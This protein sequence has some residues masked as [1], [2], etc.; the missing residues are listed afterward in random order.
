MKKVYADLSVKPRW[1]F[2]YM[3]TLAAMILAASGSMA[4]GSARVNLNQKNATLPEVF[5]QVRRQTSLS[6]IFSNDDVAGIGRK[7]YVIQDATVDQAMK[8]VLSGTALEYEL[9]NNVI[10][11]RQVPGGSTQASP[12]IIKGR[13]L[14]QGGAPLVGATVA[15]V[16]TTAGAITDGNGSFELRATGLGTPTVRI[17]YVGYIS[18]DV[19]YRGADINVTLESST[20]EMEAVVVTGIFDRRADSYTGANAHYNKTEIERAGNQNL[21]QALRNLDPSFNVLE[22]NEFGSDPNRLPDIEMRGTSNFSDMRDRYQ[23]SPNQPLFIVDGFEISLQKVMD[24]D[25]NRVAS[26][27]LLKDA[28]AKALYGAKGANGVVVI[29]TVVPEVGRMKV[30]YTG[31]F[32]LSVPDLTSYDLANA[33]EKLEIERRAG[34]YE[35]V[36]PSTQ[37]IRDELYNTYLNEVMRGVDTYWLSKPLRS[38]FGHKHTL[39]FEGGDDAIRYGIDISYNKVGGVMKGSNREN[40]AGGFNFQY[41]FGK[42][43]FRDQLTVTFNTANSSPY[44][45]FSDYAKMNPYWRAYNEDGSVREIMG[46]YAGPNTQWTA[47]IYNPLINA[48]LN[49][50]NRTSYTDVTNNFYAEWRAFDGMNFKGRFGLVSQ[51]N[52]SEV[53]LPRDHTTFRN[54]ELGDDE[55]FNRGRYTM[56]NGKTLDWNADLSANYMKLLSEKHL[57]YANAQASISEQSGDMVYFEATG[58]ANNKMDYVTQAKQYRESGKPYG[59]HFKSREVSFIASLNY[60]Y[61]DR[62]LLDATVRSTGSSLFGADRRWATFWS[63][64][65]GWNMHNE[66]FIEDLSFVDR[67]RLRLSTGYSGSQNFR[68]YQ[69]MA[70]Y[71]YFNE[72]YDNIIGAELM[73]LSNPFLRPQRTQDNNIGLDL[74]IFNRFDL[75]FDFYIK[76]TKDLLSPVDMPLSTGFSSYM[77][78]TG[79]TRNTGFEAKLNYRII[80][81]SDRKIYFSVFGSM[82]HN[83]NKL[84][85]ISDALTSINSDKNNSKDQQSPNLETDHDRNKHVTKPSILYFEGMSMNAIW[86]VKSLGISPG[87]G[88]EVF[89]TRDGLM[90]YTWD[91]ENQV[92]CGDTSPKLSGTFGFNFEYKGFSLNTVFFY[93]WGGQYYNQTLVNKVENADIQYNVD[94]R[95]YTDRWSA[96]TAGIPAKFKTFNSTSAFTRPTSRFVQDRNELE[97]TSLSIGYDFRYL[98]F[99]QGSFMERLKVQ[100]YTTDVFRISTV[101]TERG[102][103]YPFARTFSLKIQATF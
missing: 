12:V 59:T 72:S 74:S 76:N 92:V 54:I 81:D 9:A 17:S 49:T 89:L 85:K 27:T 18:Q 2:R 10:V 13:V 34:F 78:N 26:I 82:I 33:G 61:D 48:D 103:E 20:T 39:Y 83:K 93:R 43:I 69:A 66:Q 38:E 50:I 4:Q 63:A 11:I 51:R 14:G 36:V 102:T 68:P 101:K 45:T 73:G 55:Y 16:G 7:D 64:G 15:I 3:V 32:T 99:M 8:Q 5:E 91:A 71:T 28:T 86:A 77:E 35:S 52:D 100:F 53:F 60:S 95:M 25:M 1:L 6:V 22:N 62:F 90:T 65:I 67:L 41:R 58:F 88:R 84:I 46:V 21:I 80:S 31:D 40:I 23:T 98:K 29:E 97:M 47:N 96:D 75:T 37:Q 87:D 24:M 42:F 70:T 79:Q 19:V 30:S 56:G 57:L 94:R 44:G